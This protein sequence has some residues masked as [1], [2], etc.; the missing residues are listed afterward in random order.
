MTARPAAGAARDERPL[1]LAVDD[2]P[3]VLRALERMLSE[4]AAGPRL[5]FIGV[6]RPGQALE[7]L[8]TERPDLI[9]LDVRLPEM[10]G[11]ELCERILSREE[12]ALTPVVFVTAVGDEESRSRGF[13]AGAADVI[14]KPVEP[15]T[16]WATASKLLRMESSWRGLDSAG[17]SKRLYA[18]DA[19]DR[20]KDAVRER[21]GP[22]SEGERALARA[23][24]GEL[25]DLAK[26]L[27]VVD[28][29][30]ARCLAD[31]FAI[32][33]V[34]AI[35]PRRVQASL[36]PAAFCRNNLV[37]PIRVDG[38]GTRAVLTNPFDTE[39]LDTLSRVVWKRGEPDLAIAEP[40]VIRT[41]FT[42][43]TMGAASPTV[44][45]EMNRHA[46]LN[47]DRVPEASDGD[48][49]NREVSV[50]TNDLLRL[51]VT[52][53]ASDVHIEPKG[54]HAV[55]RLRVDGDL[56]EVRRVGSDQSRRLIARFKALGGM[57][58]AEKRK[59]QDGALEVIVHGRRFKLRLATTST[60]HGESVV[61]RL[62]DPFAQPP[63][64]EELGVSPDQADT[65]RG[66]MARSAGLVLV[67][68]PTGAGKSTT[69]FS[70]LD[71]VG[72][73]RRSVITVEDPV[74]YRI[75][76]A[77]Q[78][79]V[80]EKAGVTFE[81]LLRSAVRQDPDILLL[82]E[83]RDLFSAK[84]SL[85]FS[86]SGHL[87]VSSMHSANSTTAIFRL[88]RLGVERGSMADS[89]LGV[90]AQKLLKSLC[91]HCRRVRPITPEEASWLEPFDPDVP[92]EVAEPLGCP[93]CRG[94]GF[95][96]RTGVFE[97]LRFDPQVA[98]VVRDGSPI[99]HIR[100]MVGER[101]DVLIGQ[102][103]VDKVRALE[104]SP[105]QV[106][107]GVLLEEIRREPDG[108]RSVVTTEHSPER[109][110]ASR[111]S[112]P[113]PTTSGA[114]PG[115]STPQHAED[116]ATAEA[117]ILVVED[118]PVGGTI[119]E[120]YLQGAG[121]RVTLARDGAEALIQLGSA[122]FDLVV[123]DINMP[124]LDGLKLVEIMMQKGLDTPV[125]LLTADSESDTEAQGL[126]MGVED[127]ITKPVKKNV[128]LLRIGRILERR[129]RRRGGG[130]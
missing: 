26:P 58:V 70:L 19:W 33:L 89:I 123:S 107:E 48:D 93:N 7:V 40:D 64:L 113:A 84:A 83:I 21:V 63:S 98:R 88:E 16:L 28:R 111:R 10:S 44:G 22:G 36:L 3:K 55:I 66:F 114:E 31:F 96:G 1:V 76:F 8:E 78:Q 77:N 9:L 90:V 122:S 45:A 6:G 99:S 128:L 23:G 106:Y 41:F 86:S 32:P 116:A 108:E 51:A 94:T 112:D 100:N 52:S 38:G 118:D 75:P 120:R 73:D 20:F 87:T 47:A 25:Y 91:E 82:G 54:A 4:S 39:L 85:D 101:G 59:P 50:L 12:H 110:R 37:V 15:A 62:L 127:F 72:G 124:N 24:P 80:D 121:Y 35:D 95:F 69:I 104:C 119:V 115:S 102:H 11:Y 81:S 2:E 27:G 57:D 5:R 105:G 125:V 79:Q 109:R 13:A 67:V 92:D 129:A 56:E 117:N 103:A 61:I 34:T 49:L 46:V 126:E 43:G 18:P 14:A 97:V 74:E 17:T 71:C 53:R 42:F 30:L 60:P 130:R 29:V 65:L 68:G